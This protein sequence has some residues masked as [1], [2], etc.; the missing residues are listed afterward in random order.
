[1]CLP[2]VKTQLG[3]IP[4]HFSQLGKAPRWTDTISEYLDFEMMVVAEYPRL[5]KINPSCC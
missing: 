3:I 5:D 4:K 2:R 1:M